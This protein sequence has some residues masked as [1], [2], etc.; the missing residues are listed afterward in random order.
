M[1]QRKDFFGLRY[2]D[3]TPVYLDRFGVEFQIDGM[4]VSGKDKKSILLLLSDSDF[5]KTPISDGV[6]TN[7]MN[8]VQPTV[9]E[10]KDILKYSDDPQHFETDSTGV[11]KAIHRKCMRAIAQDVAWRVYRKAG[12]KCEYCQ[13]ER[14]LTIDHYVPVESGGTDEEFNLKAACR[15]CNKRKANM[16]PEEWEGIR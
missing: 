3:L 10:W 15:A 7:N 2:P 13:A 16:S 11:V 4:L 9:D 14:P 1:S 5:L 12:F 6:L 8:I